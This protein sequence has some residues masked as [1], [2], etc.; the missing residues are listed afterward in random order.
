MASSEYSLIESFVNQSFIENET[1]DCFQPPLEKVN[2]GFKIFLVIL[3]SVT[4]IVSLLGN[5]T[6]IIVEMFGKQSAHNLRKFLINLA[7]SDIIIGVVCVPFSYTDV[8]LGRWI[9]FDWMCPAAQFTQ[10]LSVFV[11]AFTLTVIGVERYV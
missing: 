3:Y 10:L 6:V 11:T 7:V 1:D 8:M 5:L 2:Y 9:F 4:S